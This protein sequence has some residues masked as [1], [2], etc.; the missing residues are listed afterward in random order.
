MTAKKLAA[1]RYE[2]N[3]RLMTELFSPLYLPDTRNVVHQ[4]RIDQLRKQAQNLTDHQVFIISTDSQPFKTIHQKSSS[5]VLSPQNKL[6]EELS[7]L[8]EQFY[9]RKRRLDSSSEEF[10]KKL[11]SVVEERP[12][13]D[14]ERYNAMVA[15]WEEAIKQS[16]DAFLEKNTQYRTEPN[17]GCVR[18]SCLRTAEIGSWK[19]N[20]RHC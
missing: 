12:Q 11:K 7:R 3:N 5:L 15:E 14:G 20:F 6:N 18:R 17:S 1:I 19:C 9:E 4:Q 16:Y 13:M 10:S 8:E 2:R